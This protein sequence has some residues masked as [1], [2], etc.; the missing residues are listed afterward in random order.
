[1]PSE[2]VAYEGGDWLE[3]ESKVVGVFSNEQGIA[4]LF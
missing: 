3:L 4:D 2:L 1:M